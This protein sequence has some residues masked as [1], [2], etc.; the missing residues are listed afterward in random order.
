MGTGE[1]LDP[2]KAP[3]RDPTW[4]ADLDDQYGPLIIDAATFP[5]TPTLLVGQVDAIL[6]SVIAGHWG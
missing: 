6:A 1:T 3:Q 4:I 2:S 5:D